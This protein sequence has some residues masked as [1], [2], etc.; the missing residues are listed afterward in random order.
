MNGGGSSSKG[1]LH[2]ACDC[3]SLFCGCL[4]SCCAGRD[5]GEGVA[6]AQ[7]A[8]KTRSALERIFLRWPRSELARRVLIA[9]IDPIRPRYLLLA[10]YRSACFLFAHGVS[11]AA[12]TCRNIN[13]GLL[14][15][16]SVLVQVLPQRAR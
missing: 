12:V 11:E 1:W 10:C 15:A 6:R 14:P 13:I 16:K 7:I 2:G 3:G 4:R 8:G 9:A 5:G